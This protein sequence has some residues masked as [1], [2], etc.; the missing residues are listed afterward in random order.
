M[1]LTVAIAFWLIEF[2]ALWL[3]GDAFEWGAQR[4]IELIYAHSLPQIIMLIEW[5]NSAIDFDWNRFW[6]YVLVSAC[7]LVENIVIAMTMG[8]NGQP[9]ASMRWQDHPVVSAVI[10][11]LILAVQTFAFWMAKTHVERKKKWESWKRDF[12]IQMM[13]NGDQELTV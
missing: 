1:T 10:S 11:A 12:E 6:V 13:A 8:K 3:R 7:V 9:Y 4:F 5:Q 2:P